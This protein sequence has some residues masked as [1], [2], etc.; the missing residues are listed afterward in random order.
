MSKY[1]YGVILFK[2]ENNEPYVLLIQRRYT[3]AYFDFVHGRYSSLDGAR[4]LLGR[5]TINEL[6]TIHSLDF[7]RMW[8]YIWVERVK[9]DHYAS[10]YAKFMNNFITFDEGATL[11]KN[12]QSAEPNGQLIWEVPKGRKDSHKE[13][14]LLCAIRELEE[15]TGYNKLTYTLLPNVNKTVKF[16]NDGIRYICKYYIG[17]LKVIDSMHIKFD[18]NKSSEVGD[19]RWFKMDEIASLNKRPF[20]VSLI[21]PAKNLIKKNRKG[22]FNICL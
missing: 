14:D 7:E 3:Y 8:H 12:I 15:E 21:K 20:L 9:T 17:C 16:V 11:R 1:S 19:Q 2:Y 13:H 4:R 6:L 22:K 5:M 18:L 10:F